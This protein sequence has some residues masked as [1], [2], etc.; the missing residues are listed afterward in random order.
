VSDRRVLG[1]SA[2]PAQSMVLTRAELTFALFV[3]AA[4]L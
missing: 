3:V 1:S 2:L 4:Q